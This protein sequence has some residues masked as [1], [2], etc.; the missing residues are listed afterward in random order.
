M[1]NRIARLYPLVLFSETLE[2]LT[3]GACENC[4]YDYLLIGI[5]VNLLNNFPLCSLMIDFQLYWCFPLYI[6]FIHFINKNQNLLIY[7]ILSIT[8]PITMILQAYN[9]LVD[10]ESWFMRGH[11]SFLTG[12]SLYFLYEKNPKKSYIFDLIGL[13]FTISY[14]FLLLMFVNGCDDYFHMYSI[15]YLLLIM[16]FL[17]AKSDSFLL[18]FMKIKL[19]QCVGDLSYTIYLLH[20]PILK[21]IINYLEN[22]T[23]NL[24]DTNQLLIFSISFS[25]VIVLAIFNYNY[26]EIPSRE[27]IKSLWT[28]I[29]DCYRKK[30]VYIFNFL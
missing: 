27:A 22:N 11:T 15:Y 6:Y 13:S 26:I 18:Y 1:L 19:L 20:L 9:G 16:P 10:H 23:K 24:C 14:I 21:Y 7:M 12:I 4:V 29:E 17:I 30:N 2:V 5:Y 28:R 8:G 25:S 3:L